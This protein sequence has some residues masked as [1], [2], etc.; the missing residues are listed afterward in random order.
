M[1]NVTFSIRLNDTEAFGEIL[2][3][4]RSNPIHRES[5]VTTTL[6]ITISVLR[7][8]IKING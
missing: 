7:K 1:K 5:L 6:E 8:A 3:D 4:E 2:E